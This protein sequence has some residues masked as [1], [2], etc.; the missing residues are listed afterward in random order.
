MTTMNTRLLS[1]MCVTGLAAGALTLGVA[2]T[3]GAADFGTAQSKCLTGIDNRF[4]KINEMCASISGSHTLSSEHASEL[5][6]ELNAAESG[7][8]T[9]RADIAAATTGAELR[10][11][12]PRIVNDYRI[13]VLEAPTVHLT[14]AADA[15]GA[16]LDKLVDAFDR[17]GNAIADAQAAGKDVGDAPSKLADMRTQ[18]DTAAGVSSVPG[19]VI[20]LTPADYNDGTAKPVLQDAR[21]AGQSG[22]TPLPA[23]ADDAHEIIAILKA[24]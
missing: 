7:L 14:I 22:R 9:L 8:T 4:T 20:P 12:C 23:A 19:T 16:A 3:A 17:L 11:L 21:N 15:E 18:L 2:S 10:D 6:D 24:L 5:T 1:R 13:Y